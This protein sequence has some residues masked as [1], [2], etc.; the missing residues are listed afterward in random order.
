[1]FSILFVTWLLIFNQQLISKTDG[2]ITESGEDE[3]DKEIVDTT[4]NTLESDDDDD[5]SHNTVITKN[6]K[7]N[8][9]AN[10]II[11]L[12]VGGQR[13]TTF[14]STL[15]AVPG[16]ILASMFT[17]DEK[18]KTKSKRIEPVAYF[19]DYNP[20]QF[21]YLLDQLREIKRMVKFIPSEL[22]IKP[23]SADVRFNFSIMLSELGLNPERFLSPIVG[24]H[25]NL[26]KTSL[27]GWKE[28]YRGRYNTPFNVSVLTNICKGKRLLVACRS[29]DDRKTL[30]V[31]GIG[32]RQNM[33]KPCTSNPYCT[34]EKNNGLGFYY[35]TD[36]VW[37][38]EGRP[39][40]WIEHQNYGYGYQN[41]GAIL[42]P[43]DTSDQHSEYRLCWSIP[44]SAGRG[45][46]DRCGSEKNLHNS[47]R[48]ERLIF[49]TI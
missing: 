1:M 10:D 43:C 13:V 21:T 45:S 4:E 27:V 19:F 35:V 15:T 18:N 26:N 48:W 11:E 31:A 46:G 49:E 41:N 5:H 20:A 22:D 8:S 42:N 9:S 17:V 7:S 44:S 47:K 14:R 34:T 2:F 28:C 39:Q 40:G 25:L 36:R 37:G 6:P 30:A 38:F 33:F 24:I 12:N 3:L 29:L 32:Q 23:P 16:S